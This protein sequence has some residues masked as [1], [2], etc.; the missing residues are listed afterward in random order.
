MLGAAVRRAIAHATGCHDYAY[1]RPA[2]RRIPRVVLP[3]MRRPLV[4]AAVVVDTSGSMGQAELDAALA[5]IK[6]VIQAAC[7]G[8]QRLLVP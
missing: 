7:V 2:R 5:E 4:T 6:G 3:A 1:H 8:P